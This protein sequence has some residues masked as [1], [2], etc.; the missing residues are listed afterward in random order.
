MIYALILPINQSDQ[1]YIN[2][3]MMMVKKLKVL[4]HIVLWLAV[5]LSVTRN[6]NI[7]IFYLSLSFC[8]WSSYE[9]NA[10]NETKAMFITDIH[11]QTQTL[12]TL[13]D[14]SLREWQ[15]SHCFDLAAKL[16]KP[17][18]IFILGDVFDDGERIDD[19]TFQSQVIR[20][21]KIFCEFLTQ[22]KLALFHLQV[23][24]FPRFSK[25]FTKRVFDH[26]ICFIIHC[27]A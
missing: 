17:D 12:F 18:V 6:A 5:V 26:I 4:L 23:Q 14:S 24:S 25:T 20:F 15:M 3:T 1:T 2:A 27:Y 8:D 11:L 21:A 10:Q 22:Q 16:F 9:S 13:L 7:V 19:Q